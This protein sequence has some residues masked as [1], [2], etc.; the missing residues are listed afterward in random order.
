MTCPYHNLIEGIMLTGTI[1]VL[2]SILIWNEKRTRR[3]IEQIKK[4]NNQYYSPR[5][6]DD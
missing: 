4:R 6:S 1:F 5:D 2:S 3:E